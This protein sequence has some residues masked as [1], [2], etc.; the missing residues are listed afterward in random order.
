MRFL[1]S[2]ISVGA[3]EICAGDVME[4]HKLNNNMNMGIGC[5]DA[6]VEVLLFESTSILLLPKNLLNERCV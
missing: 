6:G 2:H 1:I 5:A 3:R 4:N